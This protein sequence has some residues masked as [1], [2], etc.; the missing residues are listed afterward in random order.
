[1]SDSRQITSP[2]SFP[3]CIDFDL[4]FP[5]SLLL[6]IVL[7]IYIQYWSN[8]ERKIYWRTCRLCWVI[9]C[10]KVWCDYSNLLPSIIV[11]VMTMCLPT[12]CPVT[13]CSSWTDPDPAC[14]LGRSAENTLCCRHGKLAVWWGGLEEEQKNGGERDWREGVSCYK[15]IESFLSLPRTHTDTHTHRVLSGRIYGMQLRAERLDKLPLLLCVSVSKGVDI[16][17]F[18]SAFTVCESGEKESVVFIDRAL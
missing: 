7:I 10:N 11:P 5:L 16:H 3:C 6:A 13:V 14:T 2:T 12:V 8:D 18:V 1:M 17:S 9:V 4:F 15:L